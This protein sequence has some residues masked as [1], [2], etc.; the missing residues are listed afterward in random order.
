[1]ENKTKFQVIELSTKE[2]PS[3]TEFVKRGTD[4]ISF[5]ADN[6]YPNFLYENY[7]NCPSLQTIINGTADY[8]CGD[9]VSTEFINSV[10]E[11][12]DD[13][14]RKMALSLQI[15]GGIFIKIKR[16][17]LLKIKD[18]TILDYK[19]CRVNEDLTKIYYSKEW[20]KWGTKA[21]TY[22][23]YT[24]KL[25]ESVLFYRGL[26]FSDNTYPLPRYYS[27]VKSCLT[28]T[29]IQNFHYNSIIN[30]FS[31]GK[32]ISFNNG[33]PGVEER[34]MIE[35]GLIDKFTGTD[36]A[37]KLMVTYNTDKEHAVTVETLDGDDFDERYN[38]LWKSTKNTIY[39]IMQAQPV[40]FG[41]M[42]ENI[43]FN[44]Q[45]FESAFNLYNNTVVLPLQNK[46]SKILTEILKEDIVIEPFTM[47]N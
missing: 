18:I 23:A 39:G 6:K 17:A 15:Y 27:A 35:E 1:M 25:N 8:V 22:K 16:D 10:G 4:Y 2:T 34:R 33:D 3:S 21:I 29:E 38:A 42:L 20:G 13:I 45:E 19:N 30:F 24:E 32:I 36:T 14:I 28:E 40:L 12:L 47:K 5:G 26:M 9:G 11:S 41:N 37:N 44:Q 7:L 31:V 43:G 46:I